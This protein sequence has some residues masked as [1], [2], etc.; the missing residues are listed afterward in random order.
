MP[1]GE[2]VARAFLLAF[3]AYV[4]KVTPAS[5]HNW[6]DSLLEILEQ[7]ACAIPSTLIPLAQE[8]IALPD[9]D[10]PAIRHWTDRLAEYYE[11]LALRQRI[12][13]EI[14]A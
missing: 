3:R 2:P 5:Q 10:H 4:A 1:W 6:K 11:I 12:Y 7:A 9:L 14:P 13:K 8:P